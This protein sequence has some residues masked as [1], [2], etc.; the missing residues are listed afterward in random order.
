MP[1]N[2]EVLSSVAIGNL[3]AIS[4][5]P[6]MLSN[7]A[8]SNV[9]SS[10]N[11]GQQNAV[12][13]QQAVNELGISVVAKDSNIVSNLGPLEAR[14]S[15][16]VLTNN[17][18]AQTITDLKS[19]LQAFSGK[20]AAGGLLKLKALSKLGIQIN[21]QGQLVIPPGVSVLVPG[22]FNR[23]SVTV[24]LESVGVV[25]KVTPTTTT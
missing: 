15:V 16:D 22:N 6:A 3:K 9:I 13:N 4:E 5:Q 14:S 19:A 2:E 18:L 17:E 1:L 10:T 7:L 12:A 20:G 21:D 8:Y 25:F 23:E 11:L 24:T